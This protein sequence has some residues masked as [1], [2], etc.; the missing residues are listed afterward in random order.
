MRP[1]LCAGKLAL[2]LPEP[3]IACGR[4]FGYAMARLRQVSSVSSFE[5][6]D[7]CSLPED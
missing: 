2:H 7:R 6:R 5:G 1:H 3:P 4:A